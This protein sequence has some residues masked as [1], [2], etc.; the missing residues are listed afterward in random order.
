[1]AVKYDPFSG[2]GYGED[3]GASDRN[4]WMDI[5]LTRLG[6]TL[7]I[8]VKS[9]TTTTPQPIVN[10]ERWLIP[11]GATG[12]WAA[13]V[14]KIVCALEGS[15][16]YITPTSGWRLRVEDS[17]RLLYHD[18]TSFVDEDDYGTII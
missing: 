18:G 2:F 7:N 6:A 13:H 16:T 4:V 17:S 14:G 5:N 12:I 10:G 11:T 8:S 3:L 9:S 1:M 15:Y